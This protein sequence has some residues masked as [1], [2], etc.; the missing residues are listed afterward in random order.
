MTHITTVS[1]RRSVV[2]SVSD[3][4]G[5][6]MLTVLA[7][8]DEPEIL[9]IVEQYLSE[10]SFRVLTA[11]DAEAARK[12]IDTQ[13]IDIAILDVNLPGED[14]VSLAGHLRETD[15]PSVLMLS[16][17]GKLEDRLKGLKAGADDYMVK[18]FEP[19]EL[20]AR[21]RSLARRRPAETEDLSK[22]TVEAPQKVQIG[23]CL[24]DLKSHSL[25]GRDG[26]DIPLTAME[27]DLLKAFVEHPNRVLNR[28]QLAEFAHNREWSPD[29]RSIDIRIARL[30][31][32]IEK[33][34]SRPTAIL[35]E[36]GAG[37]RFVPS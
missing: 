27:F 13:K 3:S 8:D 25:T 24:L 35:T 17:M 9:E 36:R 31:R 6:G 22:P 1:E 18:P 26:E 4:D 11:S 14:G 15:G 19:R 34:P 32:K 30:R 2:N 7:V 29:D 12:L 28:D 5:S 21:V 10:F 20:L 33:D 16:A 23:V 37:Y